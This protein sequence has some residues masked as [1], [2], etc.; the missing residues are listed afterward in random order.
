MLWT[1]MLMMRAR[2]A[3]GVVIALGLASQSC[4]PRAEPPCGCTSL[5]VATRGLG[6]VGT[7][8]WRQLDRPTLD[9]GWPQPA[10]CED[11]TRAEADLKDAFH[12][13]DLCLRRC[14]MC[15]GVTFDDGASQGGLRLVDLWIAPRSLDEQRAALRQLTREAVGSTSPL[16]PT[17]VRPTDDRVIDG[18]SWVSHGEMFTLKTE[19]LRVGDA[20][21]GHVQVGRCRAEEVIARW[22]VAGPD[23]VRVTRLDVEGAGGDRALWFEYTTACVDGDAACR[24]G[25][26]DRLWPTLR[27]QADQEQVGR[28]VIAASGCVWNSIT[29]GL[30]RGADGRWKGGLWNPPRK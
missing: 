10:A 17:T 29:F 15:G 1:A 8:D 18:Q 28:I 12:Q 4:S 22:D 27:A 6:F 13:L 5:E 24:A 3:L 19:A 9:A 20:W 11:T 2:V 25:E 23:V 30:D 7:R 26:L 16:T 14:E 21:V